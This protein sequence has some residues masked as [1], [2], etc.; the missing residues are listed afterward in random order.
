MYTPSLFAPAADSSRATLSCSGALLAETSQDLS[1]QGLSPHCGGLQIAQ[2]SIAVDVTRVTSAVCIQ[3]YGAAWQYAT[4]SSGTGVF[5]RFSEQP[6]GCALPPSVDTVIIGYGAGALAALAAATLHSPPQANHVLLYTSKQSTTSRSTGVAWW[7][8]NQSAASRMN[9]PLVDPTFLADYSRNAASEISQFGLDWAVWPSKTNPT[10]PYRASLD[11][12]G[13]SHSLQQC[14]G[15]CGAQLLADLLAVA[16]SAATAN[17]CAVHICESRV[18]NVVPTGDAYLVFSTNAFLIADSVIFGS[19][20]TAHYLN[21][22]RVLANPD[23]DGIHLAVAKQLELE[24]SPPAAWHL[25]YE[26]PNPMTY[27]GGWHHRWFPLSQCHPP[28]TV[29]NYST[30]GDYSSRSLALAAHNASGV[31]PAV[32]VANATACAGTWWNDFFT[33]AYGFG[34]YS[35]PCPPQSRLASGVIDRKDGFKINHTTM[36]SVTAPHLFAAGTAAASLLGDTY[37]APGSTVGWALYS[38]SVAGRSAVTIKLPSRPAYDEK[39]TPPLVM[40]V[41]AVA[42][43]ALGVT[44][45]LVGWG[46]THYTLMSL[47]VITAWIAVIWAACGQ[48]QQPAGKSHRLLGWASIT[49][50]TVTATIGSL[51]SLYRPHYV[52]TGYLHRVFAILTLTVLSVHLF[53]MTKESGIKQ[54]AVRLYA[55]DYESYAMIMSAVL[56]IIA[57]AALINLHGRLANLSPSSPP[58]AGNFRRVDSSTNADVLLVLLKDTR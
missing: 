7:P 41:V 32:T 9:A 55:S 8:L 36:A 42:L 39:A 24:L 28:P 13:Y 35:L 31:V 37:Y 1:F 44:A 49:L 22:T 38:G 43:I 25:E 48:R 52:M 46:Y 19:G 26:S 29:A 53:L 27:A 14:N 56:L 50:L 45:H 5:D 12:F 33:S 15:T 57:A 10:P 30:C 40:F 34:L 23:N 18:T 3:R 4:W 54:D 16:Q 17:N 51:R 21:E 6:T 2:S 11:G 47:A 20:G 58:Y